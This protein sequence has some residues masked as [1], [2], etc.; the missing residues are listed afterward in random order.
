VDGTFSQFEVS[1]R[2]HVR[3]G[4]KI[5]VEEEQRWYAN[6][7]PRTDPSQ[8][9]KLNE[10]Q[11]QYQHTKASKDR[12]AY[13]LLV[14]DDKRMVELHCQN[15]GFRKRL[16]V[17]FVERRLYEAL[18]GGGHMILGSRGLSIR[19]GRRNASNSEVV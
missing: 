4:K 6:R 12:V 11:F 13:R 9:D 8:M 17:H 2:Q 1:I 18:E 10:T 16:K 19:G 5:D 3:D 14:P 15:C 7:F